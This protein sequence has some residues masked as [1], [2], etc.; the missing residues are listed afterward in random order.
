MKGGTQLYDI[1]V[2]IGI[3]ILIFVL[4]Y[5]SMTYGAQIV[6]E[7]LF[8]A[9]ETVQDSLASF[10][11]AGCAPGNMTVVFSITPTPLTAFVDNDTINVLPPEYGYYYGREVERGGYIRFDP[12]EPIAYVK[13]KGVSVVTGSVDFEPRKH[14]AFVVNKTLNEIGVGVK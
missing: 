10:M 7:M 13:C 6:A 4:I 8:S 11:G 12:P 3:V 2:L 9:P 14:T 1:I 5:W